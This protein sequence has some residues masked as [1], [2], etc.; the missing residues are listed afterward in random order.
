MVGTTNCEKKSE[1]SKSYPISTIQQYWI[2]YY[3]LIYWSRC[4]FYVEGIVFSLLQSCMIKKILFILLSHY[5]WCIS[6]V[7]Y[8]FL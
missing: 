8:L 3:L 4:G 6:N 1:N 5:N 2:N 7:V